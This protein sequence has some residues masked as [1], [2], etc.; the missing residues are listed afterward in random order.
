[1]NTQI[2]QC[3]EPPFTCVLCES[4]IHRKCIRWRIAW[5][6]AWGYLFL[7]SEMKSATGWFCIYNLLRLE[8]INHPRSMGSHYGSDAISFGFEND[9]MIG[10][11]SRGGNHQVVGG[12]LAGGYNW[13]GRL[14]CSEKWCGDGRWTE[15]QVVHLVHSLSMSIIYI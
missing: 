13:M 6:T 11:R 2:P 14:V 4:C 10:K 1:M 7:S 9:E 3:V 15:W 5:T 12:R 8:H